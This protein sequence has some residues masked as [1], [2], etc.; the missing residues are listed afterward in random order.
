MKAR[1]IELQSEKTKLTEVLQQSK[2]ADPE[3]LAELVRD[4]KAA[5]E[6]ANRWTVSTDVYAVIL[7]SDDV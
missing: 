2:D 6:A 7:S 3:F 1:L 4:T 5:K